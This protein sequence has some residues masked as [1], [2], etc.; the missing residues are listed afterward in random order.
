M[1]RWNFQLGLLGRLRGPGRG[2]IYGLPDFTRHLFAHRYDRPARSLAI[3]RFRTEP[4]AGFRTQRPS[5]R[6]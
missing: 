2:G 1:T 6:A 5:G 4:R 3:P